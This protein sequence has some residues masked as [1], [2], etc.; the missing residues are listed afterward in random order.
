MGR[1]TDKYVSGAE[2]SGSSSLQFMEQ[3]IEDDVLYLSH[4]E[5]ETEKW[6]KISAPAVRQTFSLCSQNTGKSCPN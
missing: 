3:M 6:K 2:Q 5:S 1:Q 4:I